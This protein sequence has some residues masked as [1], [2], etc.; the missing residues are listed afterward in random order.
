RFGDL[1]GS[2]TFS[3]GWSEGETL[4]TSSNGEVDRL[5]NI[6]FLE[7]TDGVF[8]LQE[9]LASSV[10][11]EGNDFV[12][13]TDGDDTIDTLAGDDVINALAGDDILIGG[14]GADELRGGEGSDTASYRTSIGGTTARLDAF[15]DLNTSHAAGDTYDSIENLEG[16]NF[17][18]L[19]VGNDDNNILTGGVGADALFGMGGID[20]ASYH[21]SAV[22]VTARLDGME[23]LNTGDATGDIYDSIENLTGSQF[24][25]LLV[26]DGNDNVISGLAGG[27]FLFG[28]DGNDTLIGGVGPDAFFGGAGRDT[29]DYSASL[30][31]GVRV[32]LDG[33]QPGA[34]DSAGD[35]FNGVEDVNGT[36][37]VDFIIGDAGGNIL[38][39]LDGDDTIFS[40]DGADVLFGGQGADMLNGGLGSDVFF[41]SAANEGGDT[42]MDFDATDDSEVLF[43]SGLQTG[44]FSFLGDASNAFTA[45]GNTE[46]RFDDAT[47]Q[48]E[49]DFDGDGASDFE[50]TLTDVA[51]SNLDSGDFTFI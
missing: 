26:G 51:L 9:V 16:S 24:N 20:T 30:N 19:L 39:G 5:T 32:A 33:S 50:L 45:G 28:F 22:G 40:Q 29:A 37:S 41:Y 47:K 38:R 12:N 8:T 35:S 18:D 17:G 36:R 1:R 3:P 6:E 7:F 23:N 48:L 14:D 15:G 13:G 10:P 43:F 49:V 42:I 44:S 27:D 46:A 31:G 11:S 2:F 34:N 21:T 25:D 4:V